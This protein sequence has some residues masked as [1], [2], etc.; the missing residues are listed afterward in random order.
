MSPTNE[1]LPSPDRRQRLLL[2]KADEMYR[3]GVP[4]VQV[5]RQTNR[6][7]DESTMP[8]PCVP[9][10][11][12]KRML[13]REQK[14]ALDT[15]LSKS[16]TLR[17]GNY[18]EVLRDAVLPRHAF[19][20]S[21]PTANGDRGAWP[22]AAV[23]ASTED[24]RRIFS[25]LKARKADEIRQ[26]QLRRDH[27]DSLFRAAQEVQR[28]KLTLGGQRRIGIQQQTEY[29]IFTA[30]KARAPERRRPV[31]SYEAAQWFVRQAREQ[32]CCSSLCSMPRG[33]RAASSQRDS[34][35]EV[36]RRLRP[37]SAPQLRV[38]HSAPPCRPARHDRP[39]TSSGSPSPKSDGLSRR[40]TEAPSP[41]SVKQGEPGR[42]WMAGSNGDPS[43][44]RIAPPAPH[45]N[46]DASERSDSPQLVQPRSPST[47]SRD[48]GRDRRVA[49]S[50]GHAPMS[51]VQAEIEDEVAI[52]MGREVL[53]GTPSKLL[54]ELSDLSRASPTNSHIRR[55]K[56][57]ALPTAP[58]LD[59]S[60]QVYLSPPPR[61]TPSVRPAR[62]ALRPRRTVGVVLTRG[63]LRQDP[64]R[65]RA[66]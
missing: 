7:L 35:L 24:S 4:L 65:L 43:A 9:K 52:R 32:H 46:R 2:R 26:R 17:C 1:E 22:T 15:V 8:R 31:L 60:S 50:C 3:E 34:D 63:L 21:K 18:E 28:H 66:G 20:Y 5:R 61:R 16:S 53:W 45:A 19:G 59:P 12:A 56:Q 11:G 30:L 38:S 6:L 29:E 47:A 54:F 33:A 23:F 57:V 44:E 36:L 55:L 48:T 13:L 49:P 51:I 58:M 27:C 10:K 14:I 41:S 40:P 62:V 64:I 37:E 25:E 39:S 42:G